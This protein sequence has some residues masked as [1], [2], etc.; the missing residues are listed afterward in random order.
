MKGWATV[1]NITAMGYFK[2]REKLQMIFFQTKIYLA[3][4]TH[5]KMLICLNF[6][7]EISSTVFTIHCLICLFTW[8]FTMNILLG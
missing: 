8:Y 7:F 1:V 4:N 5:S 3:G 2:N 6:N